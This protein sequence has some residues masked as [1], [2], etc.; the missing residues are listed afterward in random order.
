MTSRKPPRMPTSAISSPNCT[1][2]PMRAP[3]RGAGGDIG[4]AAFGKRSGV[5]RGFLGRA[6]RGDAA[7]SLR[8]G[9]PTALEEERRLLYVGVTRARRRLALS[10]A[11][12]RS[13]G[14]RRS[15]RRSSFLDGVVPQDHR[16]TRRPDR[17]GAEVLTVVRGNSPAG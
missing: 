14:G 5:G 4:V 8:E 10:W 11:L 6:R 9:D 1:P 16:P 13:A 2:A 15:R 12:S 17:Y 7:H 3:P